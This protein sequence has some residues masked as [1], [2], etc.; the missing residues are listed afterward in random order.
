MTMS[1]MAPTSEDVMDIDIDMNIDDIGPA[2]DEDDILEEGEEPQDYVP[3][4]QIQQ[5]TTSAT[6]G[7]IPAAYLEDPSEEPAWEK[8][9][10]RGV[11]DLSTDNIKTFA[12]D[13][14]SDAQPHVQWVDDGSVNLVFPNK[15]AA[16]QAFLS[17]VASPVESHQIEA[18]P[19]A[20]HTA[21]PLI[22]RPASIMTIRVAKQGDRKKRGAKDA[23]RYYLMHPEADPS[24]KTR[25]QKVENGD[26]TRRRFDA[27]EHNRRMRHQDEDNSTNDFAASM[28]DDA[29][30]DTQPRGR[31]LFSRVTKPHRRRSASP[32]MNSDAIAISD[33]EEDE[34]RPKRRKNGY[35]NRDSPPPRKHNVGRELFSDHED[36]S[37]MTGMRSDNTDLFPKP[38]TNNQPR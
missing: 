5:H 18:D 28:Y 13:F 1:A 30:K 20:L 8:V 7:D 23:S 37:K 32:T 24:E 15:N 29:P 12:S 16:R 31:D 9:H 33:S 25:K 10:L 14:F 38:R 2:I 19:F 27:R 17:F 22:T 21:K 26:Y 34:T 6:N 36:S 35:R 11:D 3:L 4:H